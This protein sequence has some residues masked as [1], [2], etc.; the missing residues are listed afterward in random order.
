MNKKNKSSDS[1]EFLCPKCKNKKMIRYTNWIYQNLYEDT[2]YC[3]NDVSNSNEV[4]R[5]ETFWIFYNKKIKKEK[6]CK[7]ET[8][9]YFLCPYVDCCNLHNE[10]EDMCFCESICYII[11]FPFILLYLILYFVFYLL[12]ESWVDIAAYF[13]AKNELEIHF[14]ILLILI[15]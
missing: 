14:Y 4:L 7:C 5:E 9:N 1:G 11:T 10:F 13:L 12:I 3:D 6:K 15:I 2:E 8:C